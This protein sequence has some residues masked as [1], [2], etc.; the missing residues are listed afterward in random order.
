MV[1]HC[2]LHKMRNQFVHVCAWMSAVH[3][4]FHWW[5]QWTQSVHVSLILIC[6]KRYSSEVDC[7]KFMEMI[8]VS[9]TNATVNFQVNRDE[10]VIET[11]KSDREEECFSRCLSTFRPQRARTMAI[12]KPLFSTLKNAELFTTNGV[13]QSSCWNYKLHAITTIRRQS[14]ECPHTMNASTGGADSNLCFH[15]TTRERSSPVG[16]RFVADEGK[17]SARVKLWL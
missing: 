11:W 7:H 15:V 14:H 1:V 9:S 16:R 8:L 6:I 5:I 17:H 3:K 12:V 13:G 10:A 2:H 4:K